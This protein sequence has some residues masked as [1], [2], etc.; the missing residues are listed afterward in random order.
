MSTIDT[1]TVIY[2]P[3]S[4]IAESL[5]FFNNVLG[6][7]TASDYEQ[8]GGR[9]VTLVPAGGGTTITLSS[10]PEDVAPAPM[11][12]HLST[13]DADAA[14]AEVKAKGGSP[15]DE[16]RD[17]AWGKWFSIDDPSGNQWYVVEAKSWG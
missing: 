2:L 7:T 6:F 11:T 15:N 12:I 1:I 14:Y 3:V 8:E 13:S 4:D 17:D 9:W 5:T 10:Y 16:V